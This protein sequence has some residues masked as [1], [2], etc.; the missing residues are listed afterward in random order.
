VFLYHLSPAERNAEDEPQPPTLASGS[1]DRAPDRRR[2]G[3]ALLI[4]AQQ[5]HHD[6]FQFSGTPE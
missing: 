4:L 2:S 6:P 3:T 5:P 1:S